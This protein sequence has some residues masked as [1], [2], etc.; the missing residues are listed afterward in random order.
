MSINYPGYPVQPTTGQG[1]PGRLQGYQQ[2]ASLGIQEDPADGSYLWRQDQVQRQA[3]Q[4]IGVR[5]GDYRRADA[6]DDRPDDA[7][8]VRAAVQ[9]TGE[10]NV[11]IDHPPPPDSPAAGSRCRHAQVVALPDTADHVP[12]V[13]V[14]HHHGLAF[15]DDHRGSAYA[16][17][18]AGPSG[19]W[20]SFRPSPRELLLAR[21]RPHP[22]GWFR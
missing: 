8:A 9:W 21:R 10:D 19:A 7:G 6:A 14:V 16:G 17:H 3:P 18:L 5:V 4:A 12:N 15:A 20:P 1:C 2:L 11:V 22:S 13:R